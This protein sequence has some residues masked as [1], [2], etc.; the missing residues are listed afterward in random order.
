[1]LAVQAEAY[2]TSFCF[3][4]A[5]LESPGGDRQI[6]IRLGSARVEQASQACFRLPLLYQLAPSQVRYLQWLSHIAITLHYDSD[7][8]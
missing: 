2:G 3:A 8:L 1:M 7:V 4:C 6:K 5:H